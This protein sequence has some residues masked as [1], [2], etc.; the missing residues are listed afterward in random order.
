MSGNL[1]LPGPA[2]VTAC[3]LGGW[4]GTGTADAQSACADLGGTVDPD[5]IGHVHAVTS[6]YTLDYTFPVDYPDRQALSAALTH[7]R[8]GFVN[9]VATHRPDGRDRSYQEVVTATTYRSGRP[10]TGTQSLVLDTQDDTGAA[11]Q[12][13]PDTRFMAFNYDLGTGA[14]ITFDTLFKPGTKPLDVL[15]PAVQRELAKHQAAAAPTFDGL[16]ANAYQ[17]FAITDDLVI[18]FF[19]E[20]RLIQDDNGP[21]ELSVPRADLASL[22]AV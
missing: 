4:A 5:H 9:W 11:H 12:G 13:H 1:R 19:G 18:F 15:Y 20:N 8:D 2:V 14:P 21:H 3:V 7:E 22:M 10:A 17:N 6:S 16:D